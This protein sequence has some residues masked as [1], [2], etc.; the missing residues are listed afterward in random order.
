LRGRI[1]VPAWRGRRGRFAAGRFGVHA[2]GAEAD[3]KH[4]H[5]LGVEG[6]AL[7]L[8]VSAQPFAEFPGKTQGQTDFFDHGVIM[9]P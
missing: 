1:R 8:G 7:G 5:E 2:G 3:L 4:V 6:P 9:V